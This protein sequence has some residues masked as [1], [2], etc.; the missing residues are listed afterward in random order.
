ML[1]RFEMYKMREG[2]SP[3]TVAELEEILRGCGRYIPQVL[4]SVV[5]TNLTDAGVE[6]V[7]EHAYE[8]AETYYRQYMCHPYHI[9]V[10]DRYL[11]PDSPGRVI[12]NDSTGLGLVGYEIDAPTFYCKDGFRRLVML[13]MREEAPAERVD[14]L[15]EGLQGAPADAPELVVSIAAAN[16]MGQEWFPGVWTH[17]WEQAFEDEAGVDAYLKGDSP[18]ARAERAGWRDAATEVVEA[19]VD[20]RYR[21]HEPR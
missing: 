15:L 14:A 5:G 9:C 8:S 4:H 1:R 12:E 6:M 19:S 16:S 11:L 7:W 2:T 10:F 13:R 20:V 18:L 3:E 21:L 17:V